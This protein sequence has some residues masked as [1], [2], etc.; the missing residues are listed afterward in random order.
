LPVQ[1]DGV[2]VGGA[3]GQRGCCPPSADLRAN[4][5]AGTLVMMIALALVPAHIGSRQSIVE[6]LQS[7]AA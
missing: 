6:A 5:A 2:R 4:L 7:E 3:F 1:P